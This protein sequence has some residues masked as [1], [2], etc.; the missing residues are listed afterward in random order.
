MKALLDTSDDRV[1]SWMTDHPRFK[2]ED[3]LP[4]SFTFKGSVIFLSNRD[5]HTEV[6]DGRG[7]FV[8][9]MA[10]L[11]DRSL[12]IDLAI[13]DRRSVGLWVHHLVSRNRILQ[14]M[15]LSLEN[16]RRALEWLATHR[17]QLRELSI[18]TAKKLVIMIL[19]SQSNVPQIR[20]YWEIMASLTL[21]K[22]A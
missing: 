8:E 9:H 18:R 11:L 7:R 21:L 1:V 22:K 2:G 15:G 3:G 20:V 17:D 6:E 10:A 5:F 16:E 12:Y 13:H 4:K 19:M 14:G